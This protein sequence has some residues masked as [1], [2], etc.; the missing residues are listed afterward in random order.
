MPRS[1]SRRRCPVEALAPL[2]AALLACPAASAQPRDPTAAEALFEAGRAALLANDYEAA[3]PKLRE[4][5]ALDPA[6]GALLNLGDCE[7]KRGRIATAWAIFQ[8][9]ARELPPH[10]DRRPIARSRAAALEG[11]LPRLVI[12]LAPGAPADTAVQRAGVPVGAGS[13]G[14]PLPMDPGEVQVTATAPGWQQRTFPVRLVEGELT[15][16]LVSP[17]PPA[18]RGGDAGPALPPQALPAET[19][20]SSAWRTAGWISAGVGAVGIGVGAAFGLRAIGKKGDAEAHCD[21]ANVCAQRGLDL[22]RQGVAAGTISTVAFLV[23]A[24][25]LGGG[26]VLLLTAPPS[27]QRSPAPGATIGVVPGGLVAT[28]V[29]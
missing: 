21:A 9:L 27:A 3:C 19:G 25:A 6:P 15:E 8:Q 1:R 5:Y 11:R 18:A 29:F 26:A 23:G 7:E 20:R 2:A 14:S 12:R 16:L 22:Q 28:G 13:L 24:A 4:S 17:E 10:D